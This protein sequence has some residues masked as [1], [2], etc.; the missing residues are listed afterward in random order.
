ML[1]ILLIL[2]SITHN[3]DIT[4][5]LHFLFAMDNHYITFRQTNSYSLR[6]ICRQLLNHLHYMQSILHLV[7]C[8]DHNHFCGVS[9]VYIYPHPLLGDQLHV[10]L[11][12]VLT[13]FYSAQRRWICILLDRE[14]YFILHLTAIVYIALAATPSIN[15]HSVHSHMDLW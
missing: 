2:G 15:C 14:L 4:A 3:Y 10:C 5:G 9:D 1:S 7:R 12:T 8:R 13:S 6:C 11:R